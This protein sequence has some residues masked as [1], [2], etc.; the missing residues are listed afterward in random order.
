MNFLEKWV[1]KRIAKKVIKELP[2]LKEKGKEIIEKHSEEMF[3][4]I[5]IAIMQVI[6]KY[7]NKSE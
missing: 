7:E 6:E 3:N 1:L 2:D 4:K 5:Q